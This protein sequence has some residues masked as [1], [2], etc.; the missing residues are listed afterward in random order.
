MALRFHSNPKMVE[1][2]TIKTTTTTKIINHTMQPFKSG[3]GILG[4]KPLNDLYVS[5][6][7]VIQISRPFPNFYKRVPQRPKKP[8]N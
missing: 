5:L 4:L 1:I 2:Q 8:A 3:F 6:V 7:N